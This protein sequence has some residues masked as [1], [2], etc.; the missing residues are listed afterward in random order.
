LNFFG[1]TKK[2][3]QC[4]P[5]VRGAKKCV[6]TIRRL[7]YLGA[8]GNKASETYAEWRERPSKKSVGHCQPD[9]GSGK[10]PSRT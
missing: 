2:T 8:Q 1:P 4:F 6:L 5:N 10:D 3:Y 9:L 7:A